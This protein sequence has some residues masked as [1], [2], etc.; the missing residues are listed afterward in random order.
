MSFCERN[1]FTD[2]ANDGIADGYRST[3]FWIAF[4]QGLMG[5]DY[6]ARSD[7]RMCVSYLRSLV[8]FPEVSTM[9]VLDDDNLGTS[10]KSYLQEL[11]NMFN[12]RVTFFCVNYVGAYN[13]CWIG[14]PC[15]T[16][17]DNKC[18]VPK[19]RFIS[20]A[21]YG[22]HYT[23]IVSETQVSRAINIELLSPYV[24][25]LA[26]K[27]GSHEYVP[28]DPEK[29]RK[30][31]KPRQQQPKTRE[32][33][34]SSVVNADP[35]P[36][37]VVRV[38]EC[39]TEIKRIEEY[40]IYLESQLVTLVNS[41]SSDQL[42]ML[43]QGILHIHRQKFARMA[44]AIVDAIKECNDMMYVFACVIEEHGGNHQSLDTKGL[45][46]TTPPHLHCASS[47]HHSLCSRIE[48]TTHIA[49]IKEYILHCESELS[50]FGC[51]QQTSLPPGIYDI[52]VRKSTLI[53]SS[54]EDAIVDSRNM[55][56]VYVCGY[57]E[58]MH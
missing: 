46:P 42:S 55:L 17:C 1:S 7:G 35:Q 16:F 33:E 43:Q 20:I 11:C 6:S 48:Y 8:S 28:E 54:I 19:E 12:V 49:Q 5:I 56:Y 31:G 25:N 29:P 44:T 58:M 53:V 26:D 41:I 14:N 13:S 30:H 3:C 50:V 21:S 39:A 22:A 15:A 40:I 9:F 36:S 24:E 52:H 51:D 27:Y 57:E 32:Y 18:H 34:S 2:I 4:Y 10:H 45:Q 38:V 37:E 47:V 23:L